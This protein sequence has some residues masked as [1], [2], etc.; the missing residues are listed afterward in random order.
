[1]CINNNYGSTNVN[2]NSDNDTNNDNNSGNNNENG[3]PT[4]LR[5]ISTV[6]FRLEPAVL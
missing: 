6:C 1:M 4:Q 2:N 3:L 5:V